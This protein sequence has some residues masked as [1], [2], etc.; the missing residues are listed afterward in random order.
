METLPLSLPL[1]P[2]FSFSL[3]PPLSSLLR[4]SFEMSIFVL[5]M[6]AYAYSPRIYEAQKRG[7]TVEATL[8]DIGRP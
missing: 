3:C 6:V 5:E 1:P 4:Y 8:E 7:L 2:S